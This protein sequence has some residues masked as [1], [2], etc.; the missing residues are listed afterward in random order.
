[1]G[2]FLTKN[3]VTGN[4]T[5][6]CVAM[7]RQAVGFRLPKIDDKH[8]LSRRLGLRADQ[9]QTPRLYQATDGGG[10]FGHKDTCLV[11]NNRTVICH[12]FCTQRHKRQTKRRFAGT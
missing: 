4:I 6:G 7:R 8:D 2:R 12:K 11:R 1:M 9:A 5:Q 3:K 10:A